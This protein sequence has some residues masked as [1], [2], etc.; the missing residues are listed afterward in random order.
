LVQKRSWTSPFAVLEG[1]FTLPH[2][3]PDDGVNGGARTIENA[4]DPSGTMT[5]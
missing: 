4:S 3:T 2:E 1:R 5:V